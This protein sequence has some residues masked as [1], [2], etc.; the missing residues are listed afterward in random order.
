MRS[1]LS[2]A[3]STVNTGTCPS[4]SAVNTICWPSAVQSPG[5]GQ[6]SKALPISRI[7]PVATSISVSVGRTA[8]VEER[9]ERTTASVRPS[10]E[11]SGDSLFVLV[12]APSM[13]AAFVA[14]SISRIAESVS[15]SWPGVCQVTATCLPSAEM[16]SAGSIDSSSFASGVRST[17]FGAV[18]RVRDQVRV[19]HVVV[20]VQ[21]VVP[22]PHRLLAEVSRTRV[23]LAPLAGGFALL[24]VLDA[25]QYRRKQCQHGARSSRSGRTRPRAARRSAAAVH[26]PR[27]A[28]SRPACA[29]PPLR[30]A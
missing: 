2:F 1:T 27:R 8:L 29:C 21:P 15:R 22:V 26:R 3:T 10:G 11:I 24:V 17:R 13:R 28:G 12:A 16:S 23:L 14:T 4:R 20:L 9:V 5:C 19:G 7:V 6:A 18:G 30:P 25:R